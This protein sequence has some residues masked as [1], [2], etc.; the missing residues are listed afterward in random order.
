MAAAF[1]NI[2]LTVPLSDARERAVDPETPAYAD[3]EISL[4]G[5]NYPSWATEPR[6]NERPTA[7]NYHL[8]ENNMDKSLSTIT[9]TE[10][11]P[12]AN[13]S[14][15]LTSGSPKTDCGHPQL[16]S[17]KFSDGQTIHMCPD[18]TKFDGHRHAVLAGA[19]VST[20]PRL[21]KTRK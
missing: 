17:F 2:Y 21:H 9:F 7:P 8:K 16:K 1:T 5:S 19:E 4:R 3:A 10:H 14:L 20:T 12:I 13:A 15:D 6:K 18:C 11:G